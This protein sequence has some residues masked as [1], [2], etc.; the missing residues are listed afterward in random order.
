MTI[1]QTLQ[2]TVPLFIRSLSG[3]NLSTLTATAYKTDISQ[4]LQWV[5]ENDGTVL[6]P[7]HLTRSHITDYL[8]S[9]AD[10]GRS[11][12]TRARKLA[13]I[14]EYCKYLAEQSSIP[15]SPAA[16][17]KMPKKEKKQKSYLRPDEYSKMLALAGGNSRDFCILQIFLQTGIR[18]EPH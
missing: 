10:Q 9:L 11:G 8:S 7:A 12:V 6:S 3:R 15:F 13:A 1:H 17:I 18:V 16:S 4:F 2:Q 14:R 5:V